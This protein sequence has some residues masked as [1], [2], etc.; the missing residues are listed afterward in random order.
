MFSFMYDVLSNLFVSFV[1]LELPVFFVMMMGIALFVRFS[2]YK[3]DRI[4][5]VRFNMACRIPI[6]IYWITVLLLNSILLDYSV[7]EYHSNGSF[8]YDT[9]LLLFVFV[10]LFIKFGNNMQRYYISQKYSSVFIRGRIDKLYV[11]IVI[12]IAIVFIFPIIHLLVP[13]D[14]IFSIINYIKANDILK[15]VFDFFIMIFAI[16]YVYGGYTLIKNNLTTV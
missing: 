16:G 6:N 14:Y 4:S 10:I 7:V 15:F 1:V 11:T 2:D 3:R 13:F 5:S 8:F 12:I 9:L